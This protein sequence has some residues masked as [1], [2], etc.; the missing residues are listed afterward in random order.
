MDFDHKTL[1]GEHE[2]DDHPLLSLLTMPSPMQAGSCFMEQVVSYLLL[3]GNAFIECL[4]DNDGEI[5]GLKAHRPDRVRL[6]K[7]KF[8]IVKDGIDGSVRQVLPHDTY[9][10][11][12]NNGED[13]C[14]MLHLKLFNPLSDDYGLS[15]MMAASK[16]VDQHNAVGGHNLSLLNNGGRPSGAL[17][18]N[19][20]EQGLGLSEMQRTSLRDDLKKVLEGQNNAGRVM[21]LEGDFS[22]QE[23]GLTPKD[24]DFT[25]GKNCAAREIC[26]AFG[27][28]PMLA[29]VPG[30]ATFA[31]YREARFHLWEDTIL[32]LL[33]MLVT[34]FNGWLVPFYG[35]NLKVGYDLDS[36]QAL[37]PKREM[38]W[39]KIVSA[40]FLTRNEKRQA[41]GYGPIEGGDVL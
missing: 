40:S 2:V 11:Y 21:V 8:Y 39:Q 32:P 30:D 25:E 34:E 1:A 9:T 18:V 14:R 7:D 24:L 3:S 5:Y 13:N 6:D 29:G 12:K 28:P 26:Q 23:M 38:A 31:N 22:W 10:I 37:A 4:M 19:T 15:P 27:V 35:D 41:V 16:A 20:G 33:D 36:I 17:V